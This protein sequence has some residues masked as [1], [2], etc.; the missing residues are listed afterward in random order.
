MKYTKFLLTGNIVDLDK[1]ELTMHAGII[2]PVVQ[3]AL[4]VIAISTIGIITC[5]LPLAAVADGA[6]AAKLKYIML[7]RNYKLN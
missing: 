7:K 4:I 2:T 3:T 5:C 6:R 1:V